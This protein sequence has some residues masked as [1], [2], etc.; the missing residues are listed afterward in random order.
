[1]SVIEAALSAGYGIKGIIDLP[2]EVGKKVCGIPI[3]GTDEDMARYAGECDF[4]I[5]LGF[6]TDPTLR[7]TMHEKVNAAGGHLATVIASTAHVS[8]FAEIGEGTVILHQA[9]VNAGAKIGKGCIINTCANIEHSAIVGDYAHIS[10][11]AMVNGDC[12]VG[13]RTFLGSGTVMVNGKSICEDCII[14]A[15]SVVRKDIKVPGI[16]NGNPALLMKKL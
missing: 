2:Q 10:T 1:M 15:G 9:S 14:G 6:I 11:G 3:L 13:A 8:R 7:I 16:Y 12:A 4:V 5:S